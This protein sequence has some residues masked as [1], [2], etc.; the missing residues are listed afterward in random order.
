MSAEF[1]SLKSACRKLGE[2]YESK[3][4]AH[5]PQRKESGKYYTPDYIVDF[6]VDET[7]GPIIEEYERN[8]Q[9]LLSIRILDPAMGCGYFLAAAA[10]Y[11]A[12][13]IWSINPDKDRESVVAEVLKNCI[14]GIDI[15]EDAV[16][17]ASEVL[18]GAT[19]IKANALTDYSSLNLD[20]FDAVIG[21]P[22]YLFGENIPDKEVLKTKF[23]FAKGQFDVYWLFYEMAI[24]HYLKDGGRHGYIVPDAI[25]ARD[26]TSIIRKELTNNHSICVIMHSGEV[27]CDPMVSTAVI[28]WQKKKNIN[29]E[30][31]IYK[32]KENNAIAAAKFKQSIIANLPKCKWLINADES[33]LEELNGIYET[34]KL[35]GE[36]VKISRGEE[37][38]KSALVPLGTPD[39]IPILS[40]KD[41]KNGKEPTPSKAIPAYLLKKD[42]CKYE[43]PKIVFVKT[44]KSI[45]AS[46]DYNNTPTLQSVY[47]I[48]I[49]DPQYSPEYVCS[50]LNSGLLNK[51]AQTIFTDYKKTFPQFNQSTIKELPIPKIK[52]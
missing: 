7:I 14:F 48:H 41:I 50:V 26:E 11:L 21:N 43:S 27:F 20:C 51:I 17:I 38:G 28:I 39:S 18:Q 5:K 6:I 31:D 9:D 49:T 2:A 25:L 44:G 47:N 15:D 42:S 52:S 1:G 19:L 34:S 23:S 40:G 12:N 45:I 37:I 22:P 36:I 32:L 46:V 13:A 10:E 33:Y 30:I 8:A 3:I 24:K 29:N 4:R 35:L 16:S